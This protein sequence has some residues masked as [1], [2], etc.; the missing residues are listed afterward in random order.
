[1]DLAVEIVSKN[2]LNAR[3]WNSFVS[4]SLGSTYFCTFDWWVAFDNSFFLIVRNRHQEIIAGIPFRIFSKLPFPS[5][6]FQVCWSDTSVLVRNNFSESVANDLKSGALNALVRHVKGKVIALMLS[7]KVR[8]CDA[9]L[10]RNA[11]FNLEKCAT[12]YL[13]LT[14]DLDEVFKSFSKGHRNAIRR[15]MKSEVQVKINEGESAFP[16]IQDY[17]NLQSRLFE[18][19]KGSFSDIYY[20]DEPYLK[21]ILSAEYARVFL[22]IAYYNSSPAAGGVLV[23]SNNELF[24]Y[25]AASDAALTR[26]CF[27]SHYLEYEIIRYAKINGFKKLDTGNI[28]FSPDIEHPD[29]GTYVFKKGF[30]GERHEFDHGNL[31]L[32][33]PGYWLL[34][35][36]R[37]LENNKTLSSIYK[38]LR[39]L[40]M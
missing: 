35:K 2:Y 32:N 28:P 5:R 20:K 6:L 11:G 8:L 24:Y 36:I 1:M 37:K 25:L 15:G 30:G 12:L 22:A 40:F 9:E 14:K 34:W 38:W 31:V 27:A 16:Y 3:E 23:S 17:C 10:L 7:S 13:D 33:K 29:Y 39:R 26:I 19:K 4:S 18:N 21:T